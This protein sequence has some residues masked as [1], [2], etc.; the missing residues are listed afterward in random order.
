VGWSRRMPDPWQRLNP[1]FCQIFL[2]SL[3][4]KDLVFSSRSI[5]E[6]DRVLA[7]A[8]TLEPKMK[9]LPTDEQRLEPGLIVTNFG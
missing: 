9:F 4:F 3:L 1:I 8:Q 5:L 7:R 6:M 2:A